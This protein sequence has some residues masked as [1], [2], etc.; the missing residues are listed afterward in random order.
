MKSR[1]DRPTKTCAPWRPVR[2]KKIVVN[3]LSPGWKP[4]RAYSVTCVARNVKPIR[5]VS[6]RPARR[7]ARLPRLI[8]VS[9]Q[10]IVKLD[11]TR[12]AV[13]IPAT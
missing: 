1:I 5:N 9:A 8:E 6:T 3:A 12:I 7:P 11:V 2:Q 10:C 13:L 4:I